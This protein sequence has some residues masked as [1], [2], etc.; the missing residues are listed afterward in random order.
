M[1]VASLFGMINIFIYLGI[2]IFGIYFLVTILKLSKQR[3]EYLKDIREELKRS[4][5]KGL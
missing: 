4:N 2:V 5:T 1:G 3:N